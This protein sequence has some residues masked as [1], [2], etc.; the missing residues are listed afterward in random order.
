MKAERWRQV[1]QLFHAALERQPRQRTDFLAHACAGDA[2]LCQEVESLLAAHD[3]AERFIEA[4]AAD[5][6]A[7]LLAANH[8]RLAAGRTVGFYRMVALLGTGG[9]GEVYLAEDTRLGRQVALKLLPAEFTEDQDRLRRFAR[10]ARAASALNHPNLITI[11]DIGEV[12]GAHFIVTEFIEGETLRQRMAASA[13]RQREALNVAVQVASALA[14]A[15]KAGIVH[16]DIKPENIMLRPDGLVKVLDFGLAKLL[17]TAAPPPATE[18]L[19]LDRVDTN[20]G[21]L[22]GT[23]TYMS[24]EQA[25]G[26]AVDR[27]SDIFSLGIVIYEMI[28]GQVPFAG[29]TPS[30]TLACILEKEPVPLS[31]AVLGV[32]AELERIV[33]KAL[34]KDRG[35]RYQV[36][37]DLLI[38]LRNLKQEQELRSG[39]GAAARDR[40]RSRAAVT[41]RELQQSSELLRSIKTDEQ[42][43]APTGE[44]AAARRGAGLERLMGGIKRH[45]KLAALLALVALLIAVAAIWVVIKPQAPATNAGA[46]SIAVLPFK[47]LVADSRNESLEMGMAD[48]LI[49]KLSPIRQLIVQP[50]SAVRKYTA[51]EQDPIAAGRQLGVDYVLEGNLQMVG[52]RT[53]ATVRLLSVKDGSVVWTDKCDEQCS[54]LFELQDAIAGRIAGA[55][56]LQLTGDERRQLAK[57]YTENAEAYQLYLN[58]TLYQWKGGN[59]DA[60]KALDY[61]NQAVR[62]DPNFGLAWAGM[63]SCYLNLMALSIL[64]PKDG[65]P[66][67]KA[68]AMKALELD[69]TLAA[70][71]VGMA[72]IKSFEWDFAGADQEFRR[73]LELNPNQAGTHGDYAQFLSLMG[74]YMEALAEIKRAQELNPLQSGFRAEAGLILYLARRYDEAIMQLQTVIDLE[75]ANSLAHLWLG[76]NYEAQGMYDAA[77]VEYKKWIRSG[78]STGAQ[79]ILGRVLAKSGRRSEAIAVLNKMKATNAYVAPDDLAIL[80]IGLGDKESALTLLQKAYNEHIPGIVSI[81][82]DPVYDDL[83]SDPRF[84]EL[85][86]KVGLTP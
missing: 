8:S 61:C 36:V 68:A 44:V 80:Y 14:A 19:W 83:R 56:V 33:K 17:E 73:T 59:E 27:R 79:C 51:L 70:A 26:L 16:R 18:A 25:R 38:D 52:E 75:P 7:D 20:T 30:D 37:K 85:V 67:M 15:H 69:D 62:L 29:A 77:I 53:R 78:D 5:L 24:P 76:F 72:F 50:I 31:R 39:L 32:P 9:M 74:R 6:A 22:M 65:M 40:K 55:L 41:R 12:D 49:N 13:L 11:H 4:P 28:A 1:D 35:Q 60:K 3:Q 64:D 63:A 2:A 46:K 84:Q 21:L 42:L 23:F 45:N 71:H 82:T 86:R 48:T 43:T 10:E 58:A 57:H 34:A 47:P 66:K 54:S 81:K